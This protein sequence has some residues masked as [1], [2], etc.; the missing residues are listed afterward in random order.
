[1]SEARAIAA[2]L[3]TLEA[4]SEA[5]E[6]TEAL[7]ERLNARIAAFLAAGDTIE[8]IE[9]EYTALVRL[10]LEGGDEV[11]LLD[12]DPQVDVAWYGDFEVRPCPREGLWVYRKGRFGHISGHIIT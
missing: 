7:I 5:G 2:D 1:M 10:F 8:W 11:V 12:P 3:Q 9:A 4:E 6:A